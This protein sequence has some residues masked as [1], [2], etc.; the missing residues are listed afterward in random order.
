MKLRRFQVIQG[1]KQGRAGGLPTMPR[2]FRAYSYGNLTRADQIY[3]GVKF[4]WYCLERAEPVAPYT[5]VISGYESLDGQ[6][7]DAMQ[8]EIDRYFTDQETRE[9]GVYLQERYGLPLAVEEVALPLKHKGGFFEEG[10]SVIYDFLELCAKPD[11]PLAFKVWG[12]YT[13]TRCLSA[14]DLDNALR[15]IRKSLALL[16][17]KDTFSSG[18]LEAVARTLHEQDGLVV[19]NQRDTD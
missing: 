5:Q 16:G 1:G 17:L 12:Y 4:N 15:F 14:S 19:K 11:Y 6:C 9:L 8:R 13:L 3:H 7:R 10:G 18:D 2:L